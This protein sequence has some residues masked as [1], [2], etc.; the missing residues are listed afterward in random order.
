MKLAAWDYSGS[1]VAARSSRV[2][3]APGIRSRAQSDAAGEHDDEE[4]A[5]AG[6]RA[7]EDQGTSSSDVGGRSG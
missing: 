3:A 2:G 5:G 1:E 6:S 7:G 4:H